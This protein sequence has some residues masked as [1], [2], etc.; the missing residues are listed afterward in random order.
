MLTSDF[1]FDMVVHGMYMKRVL[2]IALQSKWYGVKLK[3]TWLASL[4]FL[5]PGLNGDQGKC[6]LIIV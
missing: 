4:V 5:A 6:Y 2:L 1:Y 3:C